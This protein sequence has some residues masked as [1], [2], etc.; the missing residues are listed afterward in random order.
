MLHLLPLGNIE[1]SSQLSVRYHFQ[2][3]LP[4]GELGNFSASPFVPLGDVLLMY[5]ILGVGYLARNMLK[6]AIYFYN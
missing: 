6:N 5:T 3:V 2:V 1:T 4:S